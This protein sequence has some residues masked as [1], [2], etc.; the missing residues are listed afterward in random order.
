M[1][2]TL[3]RLMPSANS[4]RMKSF[5]SGAAIL[6]VPVYT[7]GGNRIQINDNIYGI[8]QEIHKAL[9]STTYT[10]ETMKN[11]NDILMMN[12]IIN[13]LGYTGF[14]DKESNR[15]TFFRIILPK[16]VENIQNKTFNEI[17]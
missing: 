16:L 15:K 12:N 14:G 8:T 17:V 9:T 11:E 4:L 10:G 5:R 7:L 2:K 1:T 6:G 13:D 3:G